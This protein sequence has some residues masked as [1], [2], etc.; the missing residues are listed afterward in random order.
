MAMKKLEFTAMTSQRE[1]KKGVGT[2]EEALAR[3]R[4]DLEEFQMVQASRPKLPPNRR[5]K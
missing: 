1:A 3:R 4:R 5:A 2:R